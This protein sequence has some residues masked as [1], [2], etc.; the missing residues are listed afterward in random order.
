M[1][2]HD[3][4]YVMGKG[5]GKG[6][7]KTKSVKMIERMGKKAHARVE[8]PLVLTAGKVIKVFLDSRILPVWSGKLRFSMSIQLLQRTNDKGFKLT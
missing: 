4:R 1:N 5:K 2:I 3:Q 8:E 7:W 6:M